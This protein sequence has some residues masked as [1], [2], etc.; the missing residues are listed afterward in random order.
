[1]KSQRTLKTLFVHMQLNL[2][3]FLFFKLLDNLR[4]ILLNMMK[5]AT[6]EEEHQLSWK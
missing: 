4:D 3:F 1:M 6:L 5:E 2:F